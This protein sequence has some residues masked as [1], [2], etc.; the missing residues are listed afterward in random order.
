MY[1]FHNINNVD[2]ESLIEYEIDWSGIRRQ[3]KQC[4]NQTMKS[5]KNMK[6]KLDLY[7]YHLF[8]L[9]RENSAERLFQANKMTKNYLSLTLYHYT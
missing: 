4:Q 1:I 7:G 6:E 5:R 2:V 8:R 3:T 9:K